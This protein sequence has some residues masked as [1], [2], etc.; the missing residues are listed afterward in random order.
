M[1]SATTLPVSVDDLTALVIEQQK[2]LDHQSLFI[3]Q[4]LEQIKLAQHNRFGVKSEAISPDQL[5]LLLDEKPTAEPIADDEAHNPVEP[6]SQTPTAKAKRGRRALPAHLP[7]IEI[8]H[9]LDDELCQ[10]EHCN[11]RMVPLSEKVT[12]Q[13][14][15][16]P[17]KVRVLRH[18]RTTY[19]CPGCKDALNT[20]PLP[21]QPIPKSNATPSLLAWLIIAKYLDGMPLYRIE[22]KLKRYGMPLSRSTQACWMIQCGQ[23][24]QPLIN[25]MRDRLMSYDIIAMDESRYHVLKEDGKTPQSQSY[26]WVQRGGPPDSPVIL[27]D[28]DP[29]RSQSVPLRL[30]DGF[31]GY[32]QTDAYEGYGAVCRENKLTS[33][34]CMAHA[35][36][37]FDEALKAQRSVDPNKQKSTLAASALKQIQALYKIERDIKHLNADEKYAIRQEQAVPLLNELKAWLATNIV[38]VPPRSTLGKAMNYLHKQW[39]KLTVYTTDGRLRIDNNLCE[40]AVRPFVMGRKAWLFAASVDGAKAS[41]NLY[42]LVETAKA[43]GHEPHSYI[44]HVLTKLPAAQSLEDIEALLPFNLE[45]QQ[46]QAV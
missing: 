15:I 29:T 33:V 46:C 41:A 34:G 11:E 42:S 25:L 13:L 24:I 10:C 38:V 7:R 27:Y 6:A 1:S 19:H 36:R 8:N 2:K 21:P 44:Q 12:E 23:L 30:L 26:I 9:T 37:K 14:D 31:N 22:R 17:A 39:D 45:P 16:I 5:R 18:H 3:E 40:N 35:R 28:Y 43:D 20:A 4:L 32:L